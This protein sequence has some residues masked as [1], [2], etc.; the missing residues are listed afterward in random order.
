V[1]IALNAALLLGVAAFFNSLAKLKVGTAVLATLL[2]IT[3]PYFVFQTI[4]TWPK[5][6]AAFFIL[7]ALTVAVTSKGLE[8]L[9]GLLLALAYLSHPFAGAFL[10]GFGLFYLMRNKIRS[11]YRDVI[12]MGLGFFFAAFPWFLWKIYLHLP[13]DLISQNFNIVGQS[14]IDYIWVRLTNLLNTFLPVYLLAYP[15]NLSG[16]LIQSTVNVAGAVGILAY[17][18]CLYHCSDIRYL[19]IWTNVTFIVGVPCIF[20]I[21]VFSNQAVPAL[22]GLQVLI[23]L[24]IFGISLRLEKY[25][26]LFR[27]IV[28]GLQVMVNIVL[29]G[30]YLVSIGI[31]HYSR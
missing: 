8:L 9:V 2:F 24:L 31:I 15:F 1:M 4:F 3:S 18:L 10:L 23:P 22:H 17:G 28:L 14:H 6:L 20:L 27:T 5:E 12:T 7:I 25:R 11:S 21:L 19:E 16:V 13:S 29:F 26:P 30:L